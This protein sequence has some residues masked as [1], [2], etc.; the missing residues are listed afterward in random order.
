[1]DRDPAWPA[2]AAQLGGHG[3]PD[4]AGAATVLAGAAYA[5]AEV[6]RHLDGAAPETLG[7]TA[8]ISAPGRLRRRSWPPHPACDCRRRRRGGRASQ[9]VGPASR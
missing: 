9:P 6:L 5:A 3:G 7:A 4:P 1:Q 8:E 2:I